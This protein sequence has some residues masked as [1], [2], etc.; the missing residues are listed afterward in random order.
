MLCVNIFE[1]KYKLVVDKN[2]SMI[3]KT[4]ITS[5]VENIPFEQF[6]NG[7]ITE[8]DLVLDGGAFNGIF[9]LGALFYIKELEIQYKIKITRISGCSIGAI[10]GLMYLLNRLDL[11]MELITISFTNI[12]KHQDFKKVIRHVKKQMYSV[13]TDSDV[14]VCNRRFFLTYFD[15]AK[16]KQIVKSKYNSKKEIID[17]IVKSLY[18]PYLIDRN[19]TDKDGCI[20]GAFP[21]M[22]K[23]QDSD[24]KIL[25]INLQGLNKIFKMIYIKNEKNIYPRLMEGLHEMHN[26]ICTGEPTSLCSYVNE[27]NIVDILYFRLRESLYTFIFYVFRT[28]LQIEQFFPKQLKNKNIIKQNAFI[29]KKLWNDIIIYVTI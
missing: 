11:A 4:Y 6:P 22:F 18:V 19:V 23:R 21:Y 27:W 26:F 17:S 29:L 24:R 16:G 7:K 3:V 5:L 8:I 2:I 28:F 10:M 12:R 9:M 14:L 13:I 20:D 25:F 15:T 1:N